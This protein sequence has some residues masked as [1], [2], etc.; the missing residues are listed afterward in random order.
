MTP[1]SGL[2]QDSHDFYTRCKSPARETTGLDTNALPRRGC[3][4]VSSLGSVE[5]LSQGV[6]K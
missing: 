5:R 3:V 2:S 1:N 6:W 4:C